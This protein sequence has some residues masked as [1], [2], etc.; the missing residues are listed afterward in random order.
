MPVQD[1]VDIGGAEHL[2]LRYGDRFEGYYL[3]KNFKR[4]EHKPLGW[5]DLTYGFKVYQYLVKF[6]MPAR[7]S[8]GG[9]EISYTEGE[10]LFGLFRFPRDKNGSFTNPLILNDLMNR[11]GKMTKDDVNALLQIP[12]PLVFHAYK[13]PH[14]WFE[15]IDINQ[16]EF[17]E[18][19]GLTSKD[20]VALLRAEL[21][22]IVDDRIAV[23]LDKVAKSPNTLL[24]LRDTLNGKRTNYDELS[25][26][27]EGLISIE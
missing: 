6:V 13:T 7:L 1:I 23:I 20:H 25:T 17:N 9:G 2:A 10:R 27:S 11:V 22:R 19:E 24:I 4:I 15:Y 8:F 26:I 3:F 14:H 21:A 12:H 5:N 16:A 18:I